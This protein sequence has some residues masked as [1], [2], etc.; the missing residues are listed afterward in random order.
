MEIYVQSRGFSQEFDYCWL[1]EV[2]AIIKNNRVYDIIQ[3][4]SPSLVLGRYGKQL[5]LLVTGLKSKKR[6]DFRGRIIRNS[7]AWVCDDNFEN[8]QLFR[9]IAAHALR[10]CNLLDD[11][12]DKAIE[13]GGEDGFEFNPNL[14]K[15]LNLKS[16]NSRESQNEPGL[17]RNSE[18]SK[19]YLAY[20]L[21]ERC[22]PKGNSFQNTPLV[23]VTGNKSEATL[24]D[25]RVW[26]GLSNLVRENER[27]W[28]ENRFPPQ[29]Q[30][31]NINND[32][33]WFKKYLIIL[34]VLAGLLFVIWLFS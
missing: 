1:P 22:L 2:P 34:L 5:L 33:P 7:V 29:P 21:E 20:E 17:D 4:E 19:N 30:S 9:G 25:A 11:E 31:K 23:I 14:L 8:E 24:K 32:N 13:F 16:T 18:D 28:K 10:G 12:V 26:R 15:L 27:K 6:H 3:S